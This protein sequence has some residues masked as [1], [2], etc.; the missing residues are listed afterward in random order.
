MYLSELLLTNIEFI[1]FSYFEFVLLKK[2]KK[3]T[4]KNKLL[5]NFK[6][7][8][9]NINSYYDKFSNIEKRENQL[10]MTNTVFDTLNN[11]KKT[12]IE[13]PT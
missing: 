10:K 7:K 12:T 4:K 2:I 9:K 5:S 13:A 8:T 6:I 3:I 1:K 11:S